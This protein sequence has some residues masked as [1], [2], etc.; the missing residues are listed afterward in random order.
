ML[1]DFELYPRWV[2]LDRQV[3]SRNPAIAVCRFQRLYKS[4]PFT[5]NR[6]QIP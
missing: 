6:P 4:V 5:E 2:P 3:S 1:S